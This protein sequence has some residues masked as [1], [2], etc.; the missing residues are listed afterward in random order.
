MLTIK[1]ELE[2]ILNNYN[3]T[4]DRV[5]GLPFSQ[6]KLIKTIE[7]YTDSKYLNGNK[8]ELGREKP[9]YNILNGICDVENAAKDLDTKDINI[10]SDDP[11][12]YLE[13]WLLSK[14]IQV[15]MKKVNFGK[16][17][18][19]IRDTDTRY[20]SVLAKKVIKRKDNSEKILEIELPEWKN[21]ITDQIDIIKGVKIEIHYITAGELVEMTEWKNIDKVL[22][23][24]NKG[25]S[26]KRVPIYEITG[27]FP[28]CVYKQVYAEIY[29]EVY[30]QT[31]KDETTYS[32]QLYYIAGQ[33]IES[34]KGEF[35]DGLVNL[36]CEDE[37][38]NVYK[39]KARKKRAGRAFGVG[40]MEEGEEAQ[41]W[42]NDTVLKQYRAMEYTT[43]VIGQSASKKLKGRNLLTETDDGIILEH[44]DGK[45]ITSLQ[46]LP[47]GGLQQY[48]NL[49]LQ[50]NSQLEKTTS[51][52]AAQRGEN[53]PSGTPY[54][55]QATII[56]QSNSVFVNLL[57]DLGIF[58]GELFNDWIMP[59][60]ASELNQEHILAY[61]FSAE[62]LKEIDKNFAIKNANNKT[63]EMILQGKI[64]TQEDYD[65]FLQNA[66]TFIK[67]TKGH[68]FIQ[69]PKNFYKNLKAKVTVNIT[70]EQKNKA[71]IMESLNSVLIT[72]G[73]L[74]KM[75]ID[76]S[77]DPIMSLLL[78]EIIEQSGAGISPSQIISAISAKTSQPVQQPM[79]SQ[80]TLNPQ[81]QPLSLTANPTP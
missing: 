42:T 19:D 30:K 75:G 39:Y 20:G 26:S 32:N 38:E 1:Q 6:K 67:Q 69:I 9:F 45:P 55:L 74:L 68:R 61:E 60:L 10:I 13:A 15:W 11:N 54:R 79:Q 31:K 72:Y 35:V 73:N 34:G 52:Y 21:I 51:A 80:S 22:E 78:N 44:E 53:P 46:L 17:L 58:V 23:K 62:E 18:N 56:N 64:V 71:A 7:F 57:E 14:D 5:E 47:A 76:L 59:F 63:I 48:N 66:D 50:W 16:T 29:G 12:H 40:V 25:G 36:Y 24:L 41:V 3:K 2:I 65:G 43:K 49:I 81:S 28:K 8:D 27:K 37:V 77:K 4:I 70:G 33:P